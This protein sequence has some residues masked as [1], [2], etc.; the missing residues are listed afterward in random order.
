MTQWKGHKAAVGHDGISP[1]FQWFQL[2][3]TAQESIDA[4]KAFL[5]FKGLC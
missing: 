5:R 4:G 1:R 3:E 2:V